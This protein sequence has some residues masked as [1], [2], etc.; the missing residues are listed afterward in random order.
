MGD[1]KQAN[2]FLQLETPLGEDRL[3]LKSFEG[4]EEM[5][6]LFRYQLE[7]VSEEN[8]LDLDQLVGKPV[9]FGVRLREKKEFRWWNGV[10]SKAWHHPDE[11]RLVHYGAEVVPWLW[12]LTRST[13]CFIRQKIEVKEVL[14]DVFRRFGFN[15]YSDQVKRPHT[16]WPYL[17][18]YRETHF[19]FLSRL[20]E[21]E[22]IYYFFQHEK[23]KHTLVFTDDNGV[24]QPCPHQARMKFQTNRGPGTFHAEDSIYHWEFHS[25]FES[26][27][28]SHAEWNFLTP[29]IRLTSE[30][31][32]KTKK[33][34]VKQYE[35]YDYPGEYEE[36]P[37]GDSWATT[38]M[39][40]QELDDEFCR[41]SG[42][43]RALSPGFKFDLYGHDR[44]DQNRQYVVTEIKHTA[45]EGSFFAGD[46]SG[47]GR[48]TNSFKCIPAT[49]QYRPKR[50][51]PKHIMRGVQ[52]A[53][54]VGPKPEEIH[55]DDHGQ[56]KVQFHWDRE[57]N[58]KDE[59]RSCFMRV[60]QP[61]AGKNWGAMFL[62]RVGQEVL[63]DFLEGDPDRPIVVGRVYNAT[64]KPPW[65]LPKNKNW[66]GIKTRSTREGSA[67]NY[68]ELRFD[69][70]KGK[71]EFLLHAERD[72]T[73]T[74]EHDTNEHV[75]HNR[76]LTVDG[77][78]SEQVKKD[79][80]SDVEG[81]RREQVG[82]NLSLN[83]GGQAH[84]KAALLYT[85][86]SG[87]EIHL[88]AKGRIVLD[89][90][91]GITFLGQGGSS[92]IDV[93]AAGIVIQ[94]PMVYLNC[95]LPNAGMGIPSLPELPIKPGDLLQG[96]LTGL[97]GPLAGAASGALGGPL[98]GVA[99]GAS[100]A[101]ASAAS[102][103]GA[104]LGGAMAGV[105][106]GLTSS[107]G[108]AAVAGSASGILAGAAAQAGVSLGPAT[109][110]LAEGVSQSVAGQ[111]GQ[112]A[113]GFTS[114]G[115]LAAKAQEAVG[116]VAGQAQQ[117]AGQ[118]A[119][120]AQRA[121]AEISGPVQHGLG[122]F[123]DQ[124]RQAVSQLA[125]QAQQALGQA[126]GQAAPAA[127]LSSEKPP[128][129]GGAAAGSAA[130]QAAGL[131]S[132]GSTAP[133]GP[134]APP[135]TSISGGEVFLPAVEQ[136]VARPD[137]RPRAA[138]KEDEEPPR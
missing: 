31:P 63:V 80:H 49:V 78:Q 129:S 28:Y 95:G 81:E 107:L 48:Y 99:A 8:D 62:P 57:K 113:A 9:S 117:V 40:E 94:G 84:Q 24:H 4:T 109:A 47:P 11:D 39:E 93:T 119:G 20:M 50:K 10:V 88:K 125:G 33:A 112:P 54:V 19:S 44:K 45:E 114:L 73:I 64:Q 66:S 3:L 108:P 36:R 55:T 79:L 102:Q 70:T 121:F 29:E 91:A 69:D 68:N 34:A 38:R 7:M 118:L 104:S 122:Q 15:Q 17:T 133:A 82:K 42:D 87:G 98:G 116:Q 6:G 52:T 60:A 35:I 14:K 137:P 27:K 128:P 32:A 16:P 59:D 12:F 120:E 130:G 21:E 25:Q 37:E 46:L 72:M 85:L 127:G 89:A 105:A 75:E 2:R 1:L 13:D 110:G 56:V 131:S 30:V 74:V 26:G 135:A 138:S 86:E 58:K 43:S 134:P 106:G 76:Y 77:I 90:G 103:V 61:W 111:L 71:E 23:G 51:T 65:E 132:P 124:A 67:D 83:V 5:S 100:G 97:T 123:V 115:G 92:Y 101:L 96:G 22:G 18:Q 41:G 53:I 136:P 126:I